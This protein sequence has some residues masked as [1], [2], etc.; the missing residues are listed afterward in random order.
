MRGD[1][2][3]YDHGND[4]VVLEDI[5]LSRVL[6]FGPGAAGPA[7]AAPGA[8]PG[9]TSGTTT[10]T[11]APVAASGPVVS[12]RVPP[13]TTVGSSSSSLV[14]LEATVQPPPS[15]TSLHQI[16]G[17]VHNAQPSIN[18]RPFI[19]TMGS[20]QRFLFHTPYKNINYY[21]NQIS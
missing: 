3:P 4:P 13:Q 20:L 10:V 15:G 6:T 17:S 11:S 5:A 16:Q 19:S 1:L 8:T 21:F 14:G 12:P 7:A 18:V 2:C 9:N